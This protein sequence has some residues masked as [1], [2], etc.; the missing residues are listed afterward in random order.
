MGVV[1]GRDGRRYI[2]LHRDG[3][4]RTPVI[5]VFYARCFGRCKDQIVSFTDKTFPVEVE[6]QLI[7]YP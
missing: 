7:L 2:Q 6:N 4:T 5:G 1:V 3:G